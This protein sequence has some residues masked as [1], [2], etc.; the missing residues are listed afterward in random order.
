M[1]RASGNKQ[2]R[3]EQMALSTT[4]R[5]S[6]ATL[7]PARVV[8]ERNRYFNGKYM[9][10]RDFADEQ[11]YFLARNRL[12]NLLFHGWGVVRGLRVVHHPEQECRHDH[13]VVR[14]GIALD[15]YGRE[16]ILAHDRVFALPKE[17]GE[18]RSDPPAQTVRSYGDIDHGVVLF[19]SYKEKQIEQV[20]VFYGDDT[21]DPSRLEAN[22][23]R[24]EIEFTAVWMDEVDP[25][26][27]EL[28][29]Q[30]SAPACSE[31][32][33]DDAGDTLYPGCL[34]QGLVPVAIIGYNSADSTTVPIIEEL[35][36]MHVQ[37]IPPAYL[38]RIVDYNWTHGGELHYAD[39]EERNWKLT[40]RFSRRILRDPSEQDRD[41]NTDSTYTRRSPER[42]SFEATGVSDRTFLVQIFQVREWEIQACWIGTAYLDDDERTAVFQ[43]N[44]ALFENHSRHGDLVYITLKCDFILDCDQIP[45]DG[46]HLRG[47]Y[48]TGN[49]SPGGIFESWFRLIEGDRSS[50]AQG[51]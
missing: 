25:D 43:L 24:E 32:L 23:V 49:G 3:G 48:P 35:H 50:T 22:R 7:M 10:A 11:E 40:V 44:K 45:V 2:T 15:C 37:S 4:A 26:C 30:E 38:T 18:R 28:I 51:A 33:D 29:T 36:H 13:V 46:N 17:I 47:K 31:D 21:C 16:L 42:T 41:V 20:P 34:C 5:K 1:Q 14:A 8:T 12:H 19:A 9:A 39:L 6:A 27:W